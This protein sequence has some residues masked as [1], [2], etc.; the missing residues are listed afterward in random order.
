M[1]DTANGE[2]FGTGRVVCVRVGTPQN[3]DANGRKWHTAIFKEKVNGPITLVGDNLT[4]DYQA[5]RKYH[6]GPD[7]A[8]CFYPEEHY[9]HWQSTV[10]PNMEAGAFGE[11]VTVSGFTEPDVCI[12]DTLQIGT[13]LL[14]VSQ[15]RA[16]C[17]NVSKRWHNN[18]LPALMEAT[19]YT[20]Y[21]ARRISDGGE[22]QI[23]DTVT[24]IARPYPDFTIARANALMYGD[25]P[26][27]EEIEAFRAL[28]LLSGEWKRGFGRKLEKL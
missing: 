22:L 12:G 15:P 9:A 28:P 21:Y 1:S 3:Y 18:K 14:Q 8:V 7:K 26:K 2:V 23:G 6:G 11:N 24:V 10:H 13:C 27:K 5:N 4:G 17:A 19:G 25:N 20:G 16:P